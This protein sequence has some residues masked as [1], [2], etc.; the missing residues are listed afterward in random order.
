MDSKD[1]G[2]RRTN[3]R[4]G[5]IKIAQVNARG[6]KIVMEEIK[7][8]IS[9]SK[10]DFLLVQEPY[11]PSD[12]VCGLGMNTKLLSDRKKFA[13]ISTAHKIKAAIA[14]YN[15]D[16]DILKIPEL[17]NTHF[18]CSEISTHNNS[19]Y[20]VSAYLQHCERI[21][22]YLHHLDT[23][24]HTLKSQNI[25]IC[26]DSNA[27]SALWNSKS[28]DDR[29][30]KLEEL[31]AQHNLHVAN[32]ESEVYSF[33]N[34]HGQ[35]NIDVTLISNSL[36]NKIKNWKIL[37]KQTSSDHNVIAFEIDYEQPSIKATRASRYNTKRADWDKFRKHLTENIR[38]TGATSSPDEVINA[39][40]L[41]TNLE[42]AI[43]EASER[44]IPR[45]TQFTRSVP[46]WTPN[47]TESRR[48][49][50]DTRHAYQRTK[51]EP[52]RL[53]LKEVYRKARNKY[54]SEVRKAKE[55]SWRNFVTQ[56]GNAQTWG[57]VYKI[58]AKK[59]KT[60]TVYNSIRSSNTN[61]PTWKQ[62]MGKL[63]DVL[64]PDDTE[65]GEGEWHKST[66][67][68]TRAP[69]DTEDA[70]HFAEKEIEHVIRS[71]TRNKAPGHDLIENEIIKQAW[72]CIKQ[73]LTSLY[74][75]CLEQGV[76][77]AQWKSAVIRILLKGEDKD[78]SDPK[79]YRPISLLPVLG[80]I[81][82]KLIHER[83]NTTFQDHP[84]SASRQFGF[85]TGKST[86]DAI[87]ELRRITTASTEKYALAILL[88]ISGA[89]DH[90]WWPSV[91]LQLQQRNCHRN[92]YRLLQ[93]YLSERT[94]KIQGACQELKKSVNR[95]CPQGSILGPKLWNLVF[96]DAINLISGLEL[97]PIAYADDL[98]IVIKGNSRIQLETKANQAISTLLTWC[99]DQKLQLSTGKSEMVLLKGYLDLKRP[100]TVRIG[101]SSIKMKTTVKYLGLQIG[102]RFNIM[103][104]VAYICEKSKRVFNNIAQVAKA[105]WGLNTNTMRELYR[106]VF[107]AI[108]TYAAAGWA[109]KLTEYHEK[110][111][112]S[113]QRT[114]LIRVT[115]A[116]RTISY[117]ALIIIAG[118]LPIV[119][120]IKER[121]AA[122]HLKRNQP[123]TMGSLRSNPQRPLC[124]EERNILS[125]RIRAET[126]R[127][128]QER[129]NSST[130]GRI[131]HAFFNE[132]QRRLAATWVRTNHYTVQ[133]L[134]GHGNLSAKLQAL[135]LRT[136]RN[137]DCG[138]EDTVRHV[139]FECEYAEEDR[140]KLREK[141][142]KN[143]AVW[144][145]TLQELV[146]AANYEAF[147]EY[148]TSTMQQREEKERQERRGQQQQRSI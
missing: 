103:P 49:A 39:Q 134:S 25:V 112:I 129:W 51:N 80:K 33:D 57:I 130:K 88:D 127:I 132:V 128:W 94:A 56:E 19:I 42:N 22:T 106:G 148:A 8:Y 109:D 59:I 137:C 52:H 12:K 20:L 66:R 46:W 11:C 111:L 40:E 30:E 21:E 119:Q 29:G 16:W 140:R 120:I 55:T 124:E 63:L 143:G 58:Q 23:I 13:K 146:T 37:P 43:I 115:K 54:I 78:E 27:N 95:G 97:E 121:K 139:I 91:L 35:E 135:G 144:P 83:L 45:K 125:K 92:I 53:K 36:R 60:D 145:C 9:R 102:T 117:D 61:T 67:E 84:R 69:P 65:D 131:T 96:D 72:P 123:F 77:P 41:A 99:N 126:L 105:T 70:P 10:T 38:S 116:Y 107:V 7:Q 147:H 142:T 122:Y 82:E 113:A 18:T 15:R 141:V 44:S 68:R 34:I 5:K 90:V 108:I 85:R 76:F 133:L 101:S 79:S 138:R 48:R 1:N 100:P 118:E 6:A 64:I 98:V 24:L 47:L 17:C 110:R 104:H 71:L 81:L 31:I 89:F 74:N 136:T 4:H 86:E 50:F 26:M 62:T 93:S 32:V 2:R 75:N 28:T 73:E 114:A 87:M 3:R 14:A